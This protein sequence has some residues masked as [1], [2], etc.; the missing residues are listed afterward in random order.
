MKTTDVT[1]HDLLQEIK[2]LRREVTLFVPQ[3]SSQEYEN[4]AEIKRAL[5][6][7]K[8]QLGQS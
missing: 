7:A 5:A 4:K 3:E 6:R 8:K 2:A 1:L